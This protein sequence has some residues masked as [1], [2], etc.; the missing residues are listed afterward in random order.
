MLVGVSEPTTDEDDVD[1]SGENR[2]EAASTNGD[3]LAGLGL[4]D[5]DDDSADETEADDADGGR[6]LSFRDGLTWPNALVLAA[7]LAFLGFAVGLFVSRDTSPGASSVD[8]GFYQ[9]M[10]TH[11][12]Q[13][14]E[15]SQI[16]LASGSDPLVRSLAMEV[17]NFQ[18][19]EIGWMDNT[20]QG[21][22]YARGNRSDTAMEWMGM[23]VPVDQMPGLATDE[24]IQALQ[25]AEGSTVDA[26][27]LTLMAAHH[28]GGLHMAEFA[29]REAESSDVR[30]WAQRMA[31]NQAIEVNEYADAA[32]QLGYPVTIE[33]VEV[34][35]Y[36]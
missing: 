7:A 17:L 35:T 5:L 14:L 27:W 2:D 18:S 26:T 36:D 6:A 15:L 10:I 13:A 9:D 23:P 3:R 12:E 4:D 20:L 8:V 25:D 16:E 11:H 22:G 31:R 19:Y 30:T 34:P 1:T 24:Q 21:W 28:L 29:A 33:R 32:E